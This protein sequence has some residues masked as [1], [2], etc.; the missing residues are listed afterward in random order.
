M[1]RSLAKFLLAV[2][3]ALHTDVRLVN[4]YLPLAEMRSE[5]LNRPAYFL[6]ILIGPVFILRKWGE[7]EPVKQ[8]HVINALNCEIT[9]SLTSSLK[10]DESLQ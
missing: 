10:P 9:F 5:S 7:H 2:V 1:K 6:L 4:P 3:A 8:W